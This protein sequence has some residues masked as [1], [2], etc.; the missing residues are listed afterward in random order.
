[1]AIYSFEGTEPQIGAGTFIHETASVI[2]DVVVGENCFIAAG[3][4]LRGDWSS[5]RVGS[6]TI[7]QEGCLVH[8]PP[9]QACEVGDNVLIGH[10][11]IVH[12]AKVGDFAV[13]GTGSILCPLSV[14]GEGAI[15]AEGCVV[16]DGQEI[17]PNKVAMGI[18]AKIRGDVTEELKERYTWARENYSKLPKR[19][20]EG[21]KRL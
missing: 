8:A 14:I 7:I 2:G 1:M 5:I 4:V 15:I 13:I 11:V 10:C 19:Y 3:A 9:G 16:T 20:R 21:L 18:P 12:P 17:P 6:G